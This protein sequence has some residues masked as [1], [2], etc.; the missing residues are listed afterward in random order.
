MR[1]AKIGILTFSDG[2]KFVH[3]ELKSMNQRFLDRVV[4]TLEGTGE[5]EVVTGDQIIWTPLLAK[6]QAQKMRA[7]DVDGTIFNFSIWSFPHLA[8]IAAENGQ[9]PYLMLSNLNPSYPGLV[10]MM[11]S[12]GSLDQLGIR[13]W[14]VWGDIAE[15]Q[16]LLRR[17]LAFCRAARVVNTL[18]GQ[19]YGLI[20]GRSLGMYTA[21]SDLRQ[22]QH[23]FGVDVEHVDQL[24]IVRLAEEVSET[25]AE[26]GLRWLEDN[27]GKIHYDGKKLTPEK[28]KYQVRCYEATKRIIAEKGLDFVGIKCQPELSDNYV[29]QCLSA[30]F[31]NDPYDWDGEHDP[32]VC[33]C[34]VD[35]DG[36]LT[37]QI[38]KLLSGDPVLFMDFRHYDEK[39]NIYVFCNCGS[40]ATYYAGRSKDPGGNL[41][42]VHFYPQILYY[43]AGGATVQ[44]V[45]RAG[46]VTLARLARSNGQYWMAIMPGEFVEYPRSKCEPTTKEWP[47]CFTRLGVSP[48]RLISEYGSNHTHGVYGNWTDELALICEMLGIGST[49][50]A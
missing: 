7:Q 6:Q 38:L 30:A 33:A 32:I 45:G 17:V 42:G 41:K 4:S 2:R 24:E 39:E 36:A 49:V 25:E 5:V 20:G 40:Q 34:E 23:I 15:D 26:K 46:E 43:P 27:I 10:G 35:M 31:L 12:A 3:E 13:N 47:H 11:A 22:W 44:Y 50:Y 28:L 19:T 8:A 29:T 9:P 48:E 18:R 21:V 16:H 1:K 14:R 37:M